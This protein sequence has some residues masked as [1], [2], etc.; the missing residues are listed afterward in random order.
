MRT[1]APLLAAALSL[2]PLGCGKGTGG[3]AADRTT[4]PPTPTDAAPARP[5]ADAAPAR[6]PADAGAGDAGASAD[7][8][9]RCYSADDCVVACELPGDCCGQCACTTPYSRTG[10]ARLQRENAARCRDHSGCP[11]Y[12]CQQLPGEASPVCDRGT[13]VTVMVPPPT[14][15]RKD[16]DCVLSCYA[17]GDC[18]PQLCPPC[19]HAYHRADARWHEARQADCRGRDNRCGVA[20]CGKA[21][22]RTEP[23]CGENGRCYARQVPL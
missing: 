16:S 21:G 1:P 6:P 14:R 7:E 11:K 8:Y 22:Y 2:L 18:C 12:D 17:P 5:P 13:C 9:T 10:L 15:C 3:P 23:E 4:A 19:R 20:R